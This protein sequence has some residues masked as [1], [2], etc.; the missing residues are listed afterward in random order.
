MDRGLV[1][2]FNPVVTSSVDGTRTDAGWDYD[3]STPEVGGNVRW[4]LTRNLTM[5]GTVNPDFSQV[6]ADAGRTDFNP[7]R[8]VFFPEKRPFF[9]E[10]SE[11]FQTPNNLIYTRRIV[12]PVAAA[13]VTGK[14]SGTEV[15]FLFAVDDKELSQSGQD[16][17]VFKDRKS[18]V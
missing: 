10:G 18:V 12:N 4:G 16:N 11:S 9:L 6:E 8:S 2:D 15:G 5:N 14:I 3:G 13:K 17:P 1:L 7:Q